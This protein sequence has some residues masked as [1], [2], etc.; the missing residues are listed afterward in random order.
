MSEDSA[1]GRLAP[2]PVLSPICY[3]ASLQQAWSCWRPAYTKKA[4][5]A[6][7]RP[8]PRTW[9]GGHEVRV[10]GSC[11]AY[12]GPPLNFSARGGNKFPFSLQPVRGELLSLEQSERHGF[13]VLMKLKSQSRSLVRHGDHRSNGGPERGAGVCPRSAVVTQDCNS[14]GPGPAPAEVSPA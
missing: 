6:G 11:H 14:H 13:W 4:Q 10:P 12:C 1:P 7:E 3:L 5:P 2:E 8:H 9:S